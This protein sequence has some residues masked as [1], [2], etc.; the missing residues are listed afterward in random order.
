MDLDNKRSPSYNLCV[1]EQERR[2]EMDALT[3][4]GNS[5]VNEVIAKANNQKRELD[6]RSYRIDTSFGTPY[7]RL[8]FITF[9][10][11]PLSIIFFICCISGGSGFV[12]LGFITL[13]L[14]IFLPIILASVIS[15]GKKRQVAS[16]K[17]QINKTE[18]RATNQ[19]EKVADSIT[20]QKQDVTNDYKMLFNAYK[21][22][23]LEQ[24]QAK[25]ELLVDN[26]LYQDMFDFLVKEVEKM[27]LKD[28]IVDVDFV[29][30]YPIGIQVT[31]S[32]L[33]LSTSTTHYGKKYIFRDHGAE[34]LPDFATQ[35]AVGTIM[36][37]LMVIYLIENYSRNR[38]G[39]ANQY[40]YRCDFD[41]YDFDSS[42]YNRN[43]FDYVHVF[44]T[45]TSS[46]E[47]ES[48]GN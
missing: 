18:D 7:K 11:V 3:K 36:M 15:S 32:S 31:P 41:D 24:V 43:E 1:L 4:T 22:E 40:T 27:R 42:N 28:H 29:N 16:V 33:Y 13:I 23:Y 45:C 47:R 30:E 19:M 39:L 26:D 9:I 44:I 10:C 5:Q 12:A 6:S 20:K 21:D 38:K 46:K 48:W 25:T 17:S 2:K 37:K 34:D 8:C 14:G 35:M